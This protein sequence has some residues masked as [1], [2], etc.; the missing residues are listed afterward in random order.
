MHP[1]TKHRMASHLKVVSFS[2]TEELFMNWF[3]NA[4]WNSCVRFGLDNL[5]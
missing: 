3:K 2:S 4:T 5:L 1:P